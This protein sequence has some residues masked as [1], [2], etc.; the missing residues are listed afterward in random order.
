MLI[1]ELGVLTIFFIAFQFLPPLSILILVP[2]LFLELILALGISFIL[3]VLNI[4]Y[5]DTQYI[6]NVIIYAGFFSVPI[7][8]SLDVFPSD[9]KEL[10]LLNPMAHIIEIGHNVSLYNILPFM[11][12]VF[13]IIIISVATLVGSYF[14]FK[15]YDPKIVEEL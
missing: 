14:V 13:Y 12:D 2:I 11:D 6:W 9:V 3:S 5:R 8:Y 7:L 4:V 10:L 15:F 1:L